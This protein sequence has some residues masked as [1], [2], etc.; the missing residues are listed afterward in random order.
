MTLT[1][2]RA[3]ARDYDQATKQQ[4]LRRQLFHQAIKDAKKQGAS[5]EVLARTLKVSTKRIYQILSN[6][7]PGRM[8]ASGSEKGKA[9]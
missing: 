5:V 3:A 7:K 2:L 8:P 1:R 4:E 6:G 9:R